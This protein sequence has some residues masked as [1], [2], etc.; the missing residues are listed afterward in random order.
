MQIVGRSPSALLRVAIGVSFLVSL[1]GFAGASEAPAEAWWLNSTFEPAQ[2]EYAGISASEIHP[3]WVKLTVLSY[4]LLPAVA[5]GDLVWMKGG[6]FVFVKEGH[7][8]DKSVVRRA[9]A[10]VFRDRSGHVGRFLLV[11]QHGTNESIWKK[12]FLHQ[13]I[14]EAGFSVLVSK[15]GLLYWGTCMQC[16]EF[17]RVTI[18]RHGVR[19]E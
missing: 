3:D 7:F 9:A 5:H 1:M 8:G 15:Q 17:R 4:E 2:T 19:L 13:E 14:G 18:G 11:L 10:G 12:V 16:G 6:G